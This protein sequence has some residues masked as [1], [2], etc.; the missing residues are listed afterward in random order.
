MWCGHEREV[1]MAIKGNMRPPPPKKKGNV[2]EPCGN[3]NVLY[4]ACMNVTALRV[5]LYYSY[6]RWERETG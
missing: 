2:K 1:D 3:E 4:L 5:M 6:A